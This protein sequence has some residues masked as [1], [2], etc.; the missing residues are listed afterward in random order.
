MRKLNIKGMISV[1]GAGDPL[2]DRNSDLIRQMMINAGWGAAF[3]ITGGFPGMAAGAVAGVT[4]TVVQG[5][6]AQ[7][8]V[9]VPIPT[10]PLGPVWNGS[11][12]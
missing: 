9:H 3:G 5:A 8:P 4:Q 7:M 6:V 2:T 11:K 10:V 1:G 12:G